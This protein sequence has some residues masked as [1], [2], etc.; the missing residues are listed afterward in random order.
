MQSE[1]SL[2]GRNP[3]A[4]VFVPKPKS[5]DNYKPESM[6]SD[7]GDNGSCE[8]CYFRLEVEKQNGDLIIENNDLKTKLT[9]T[10][11]NLTEQQIHMLSRFTCR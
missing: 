7:L 2:K 11:L 8:G 6:I 10:R 4:D 5:D 3:R 1:A 9:D